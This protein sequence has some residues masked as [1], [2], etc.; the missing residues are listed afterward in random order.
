MP[1]KV[2]FYLLVSQLM[3]RIGHGLKIVARGILVVLV[4]LI[5][6]PNFTLWTWRFYFWSG[7]SIVFFNRKQEDLINAEP[8][9][10]TITDES[11]YFSYEVLK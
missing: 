2:P 10:T 3:R 11:S 6:L 9:L 5:I 7:E 8:S 1:E 4:W